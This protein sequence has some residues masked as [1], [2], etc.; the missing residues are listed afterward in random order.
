MP[1]VNI[2]EI[3]NTG[4]ETFEYLNYTVLIP[5]PKFGIKTVTTPAQAGIDANGDNDYEDE[6]DTAPV[7][8]ESTVELIPAQLLVTPSD[9][10][11]A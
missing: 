4:S 8:E 5:G 11:S 2:R 9:F 3:D 10:D 7:A 6:G 1:K